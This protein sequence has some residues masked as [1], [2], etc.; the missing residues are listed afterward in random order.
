MGAGVSPGLQNRVWRFAAPGGF[1]SYTLPP[2]KGLG[3]MDFWNIVERADGDPDALSLLLSQLD[4]GAL[5]EFAMRYRE[6]EVNLYRWEVWGAGY[7]IDGGM[8]D[9]GFDYFRSWIISRGRECYE[10]AL[11]NPDDL[12]RF[13]REDEDPSAEAFGYVAPALIESRGLPDPQVLPYP[14]EPLG[15]EWDEDEV[16]ALFPKL[17][18]KFG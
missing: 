17:A 12:G 10:T 6:C 18:K 11:A 16:E 4:D 14:D 9:D 13:V 15:E 1:D 2:T 8:G 5:M 3:D 7:V